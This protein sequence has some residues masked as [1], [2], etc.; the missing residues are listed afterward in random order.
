MIPGFFCIVLGLCSCSS[1]CLLLAVEALQP[2]NRIAS[3]ASRHL[4]AAARHRPP[5]PG[6]RTQPVP[7]EQLRLPGCP[8]LQQQ[9][10]TVWR[11]HGHRSLWHRQQS[12]LSVRHHRHGTCARN[13][14]NHRLQLGSQTKR[15]RIPCASLQHNSSN[16]H[17]PGSL[18]DRRTH[19]GNCDTHLRSRSRVDRKSRSRLPDYRGCFPIS[20]ST[21]GHRELLPK[22]RTRRQKHLPQRHSTNALPHSPACLPA[23]MVGPGWRMALHAGKRCH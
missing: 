4:S 15:P 1:H 3:S 9:I 10:T 22:H 21:D 23:A 20:R 18:P 19:P 12:R 14:A 13:A 17:H 16:M 6:N 8:F 11:R 5:M 7:D 2:A